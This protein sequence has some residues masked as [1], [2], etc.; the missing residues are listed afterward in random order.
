MYSSLK[1]IV[2]KYYRDYLYSMGVLK[3]YSIYI[4][5]GIAL[6]QTIARLHYTI[7]FKKCKIK[8][9]LLL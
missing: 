7:L 3:M 8:T 1:L 9:V 5:I 6:G 4:N 2:G